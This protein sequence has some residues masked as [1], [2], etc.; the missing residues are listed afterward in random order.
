MDNL[1]SICITVLELNTLQII[2]N[3]FRIHTAYI[4][5]FNDL[6]QIVHYTIYVISSIVYVV[7]C[8]VYYVNSVHYI[9]YIVHYIVNE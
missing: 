9:V 6:Y 2:L 8:I 7:N 4:T 5:L 3:H 1:N